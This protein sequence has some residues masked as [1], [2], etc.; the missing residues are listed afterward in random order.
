V[1]VGAVIGPNDHGAADLHLPGQPV[2]SLACLPAAVDL[3][4]DLLV[5]RHE[6]LAGLTPLAAAAIDAARRLLARAV[7]VQ[8]VTDDLGPYAECAR[9]KVDA[10]TGNRA[11]YT[12]RFPAIIL[13]L[14]GCLPPGKL[15]L[16][17]AP[18]IRGPPERHNLSSAISGVF[19]VSYD[20]EGE[21]L[22]RIHIDPEAADA[23]ESAYGFIERYAPARQDAEAKWNEAFRQAKEQNKRVVDGG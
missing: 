18:E 15:H 23:A 11:P 10:R 13:L 16:I 5:L 6:R 21:E 4:C 1:A 17:R 9:D 14:I 2:K 22:G 20:L 8:G 12:R 19:A 7:E 3:R